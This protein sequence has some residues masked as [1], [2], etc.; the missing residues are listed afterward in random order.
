MIL[1]V[2]LF[3]LL[4]T[5]TVAPQASACVCED[6]GTNAEQIARAKT[7]VLGRIVDLSIASRQVDGESIEY[8]V[9]TIQVEK[10]WKGPKQTRI[11]VNT[12]GNQVLAC[13]C[14]VPFQLGGEYIVVTEH[15]SQVSSCGLTR[16]VASR[17]DPFVAGIEAHFKK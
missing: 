6:L 2:G 3:C 10:R 12:C 9:A 17:E 1:R 5:V 7:V 15:G 13:T 14:G 8:T 11:Q 16:S 4:A